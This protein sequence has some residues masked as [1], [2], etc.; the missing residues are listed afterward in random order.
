MILGIFAKI[1]ARTLFVSINI[2]LNS[3][4]GGCGSSSVITES[5]SPRVSLQSVSRTPSIL[6]S[7]GG[8]I[9]FTV[10]LWRTYGTYLIA[11]ANNPTFSISDD[12]Q[13]LLDKQPLIFLA[14][15]ENRAENDYSGMYKGSFTVPANISS[16]DK[17]YT[18][19]ISI[20]QVD[21]KPFTIKVFTE[22]RKII[23]PKR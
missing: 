14:R 4:L 16:V 6:G 8:K 1:S 10:D 12:N 13:V 18:G 9:D 22:E 3:L 5:G 20:P 19:T 7:E 2:L 21:G 17:Q 11:P 23:V 15:D